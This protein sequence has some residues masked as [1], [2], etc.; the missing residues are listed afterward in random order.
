MY[1]LNVDRY[2]LYI[3]YHEIYDI[4]SEPISEYRLTIEGIII[5]VHNLRHF[6]SGTSFS[7]LKKH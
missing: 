5:N 4:L 2:A 3:N 6:D 1:S 7:S